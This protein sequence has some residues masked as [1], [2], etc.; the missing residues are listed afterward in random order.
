MPSLRVLFARL[1][2]V[3][4]LQGRQWLVFA[5]SGFFLHFST[6][7]LAGRQAQEARGGRTRKAQYFLW[8]STLLA[9]S[10]GNTLSAVMMRTGRS[11]PDS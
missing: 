7:S 5:Q 1:T 11:F 4:I 3:M 8:G 2:H 9:T 10:A 6:F